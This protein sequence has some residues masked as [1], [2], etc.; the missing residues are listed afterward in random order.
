M[1]LSRLTDERAEVSFTNVSKQGAVADN[2]CSV[3]IVSPDLEPV[4][5]E[6]LADGFHAAH[7]RASPLC[8]LLHD[9]VVPMAL[10]ERGYLGCPH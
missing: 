7:H 4:H 6:D 8:D 10:I 2:L 9:I 5:F 1:T 3:A